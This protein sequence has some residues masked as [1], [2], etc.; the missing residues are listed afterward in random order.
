MTTKRAISYISA[1][2]LAIAIIIIVPTKLNSSGA[3]LR[4]ILIPKNGQILRALFTPEDDIRQT[5]IAMIN[6][7]KKAIQIA[8]YFFTDTNIANALIYAKKQNNVDISIIIDPSHVTK[9][10]H[11]QV[12]RLYKAGI[13]IYVFEIKNKDGIF[14]HKILAFTQNIDEKALLVTGSFNLTRTAQDANYENMLITDNPEINQKYTDQLA[15][16]RKK[17]LPLDKF[18]KKHHIH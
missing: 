6:S 11:T 16:L 2:C 10:P 7:E 18:I 17:S 1:L 9:C 5:I 14:H 12:Y 8:T 3:I 4:Q 13:P 15:Y